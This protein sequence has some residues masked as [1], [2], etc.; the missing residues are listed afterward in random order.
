VTFIG[1]DAH[2]SEHT[3]LAINRFEEE[4][5]VLRFENTKAGIEA[6]LPWLPTLE[7][8]AAKVVIG[9][10]GSGGNGHALVSYLLPL[11]KE[12]TPRG[13]GLGITPKGVI[14]HR[15]LSLYQTCFSFAAI[16]AHSASI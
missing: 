3:A 13:G 12:S 1:I 2:P 14:Y 16:T 9:V 10:E 5:G 4:K 6:F 8:H 15:I 7:P 11:F